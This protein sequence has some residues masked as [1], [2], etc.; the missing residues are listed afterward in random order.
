MRWFSALLLVGLCATIPFLM[1]RDGRAGNGAAAQRDAGAGAKGDARDD[2]RAADAGAKKADDRDMDP[3]AAA[4]GEVDGAGA[5]GPGLE[6]F[7][8][9]ILGALA[10]GVVLAYHPHFIGRVAGIL[11][12][13]SPKVFI[14]YT[15]VGALTGCIVGVQE[16]MAFAIFGIGGLM[17]FR[18]ELPSAKDTGRVILATLIGMLWGL[19]LFVVAVLATVIAWLLVLILDWRVGYRMVAKGL[20]GE[21]VAESAQAYQRELEEYGCR[22]TQV[23]RNPKKGQFSIVFRSSRKYDRDDFESAFEEDIE[24]RLKATVDWPEEG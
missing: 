21:L 7:L 23:K 12:M 17:R 14:T 19:E 6:Q 10:S 9:F 20:G 3:V 5:T 11:E 13:D 2:P 8:W 1:Q 22:I 4:G 16:Y 24:E 15:V 18:T